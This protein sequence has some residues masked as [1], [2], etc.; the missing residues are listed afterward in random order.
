MKRILSFVLLFCF[1]ITGCTSVNS[2]NNNSD[3]ANKKEDKVIHQKYSFGPNTDSSSVS[4]EVKD[5]LQEHIDKLGDPEKDD[6]I[7][8][9]VSAKF[10]E[11]GSLELIVFIRNGYSYSVRDIEAKVDVKKNNEVVATANFILSKDV[12]GILEA[13]ESRIWTLI[14]KP[15]NVLKHEV[16]LTE[17]ILEYTTKYNK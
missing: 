15:E 10:Q 8:N 12:F 1:L 4:P 9:G 11:D 7:F 17:Y 3:K 6:I 5:K 13:K 2:K 16:N 14:Y